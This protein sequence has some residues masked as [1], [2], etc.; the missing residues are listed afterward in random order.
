M[1]TTFHRD[2]L[3]RLD[4]AGR[5]RSLT[6]RAGI[7]FA[8][9]DYLGLA[10]DPR[11]RASV[12]EALDRGVAV[13]SGGSRL[14]RGNDP[15]I[16]ALEVEA[17]ALFGAEACLYFANGFA[18]N[19]AL[20]STL[21][22]L[23][24]LIVH[25]AMIHA[26]MHDGLR[27]ARAPSVAAGH[28]DALAVDDAIRA[29]RAGG[30]TGTPWIAFETLYS[31]DGDCAPVVELAEVAARHDAMLLVDEAHATGVWGAN[32][33]GL[34]EELEGA[35][36]VIAL[37]TCG[38][39]LGCQGALVTGS[40]VLID[41]LIN[42]ARP[43]IFST[44]PS[45]LL[46]SAVRAA[47]RIVAE[48]PERRTRLHALIAHAEATLAPH[49]VTAT[50]TQVMPLIIGEDARTM[51]R[52][53]ALQAKGFDVRGIRPPTVAPGTARLRIAVT[54]NVTPDDVDA[55]AVALA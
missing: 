52:A 38:K 8:S 11:L 41:F 20:L 3:D 12:S 51:A 32:G 21:P 42:R 37:H 1:S 25:D 16:A 14:L 35:D 6:P 30:G 31:M 19:V 4:A 39:A 50:G 13:G 15:E 18:A 27:L 48:E 7:D 54:L 2:D 34:A 43:F 24:D 53:A 36:N 10:S 45:P 40:Q 47:L 22:Q 9:N 28:N 26:S 33:R 46:A 49:G 5:L 23:G 44:A 55:L 17:A 29:W